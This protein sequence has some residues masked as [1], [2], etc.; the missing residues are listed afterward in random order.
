MSRELAQQLKMVAIL[1]E[2]ANSFPSTNVRR[3]TSL[4]TPALSGPEVMC[5]CSHTNT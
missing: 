3:L 4:I 5:T 2:G 1:P